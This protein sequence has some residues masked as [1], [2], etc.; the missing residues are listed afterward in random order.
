MRVKEPKEFAQLQSE[1]ISRQA[2][3]LADKSKKHARS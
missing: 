3:C 1:F 2:Q